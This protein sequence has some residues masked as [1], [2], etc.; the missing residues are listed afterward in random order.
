MPFQK[1]LLVLNLS[2][3][4]DKNL[5]KKIICFLNS[6][7][8]KFGLIFFSFFIKFLFIKKL[9]IFKK[10]CFKFRNSQNFFFNLGVF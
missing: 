1:Y 8:L 5:L 7:Y 2:L 10:K 4:I 3:K 9:R 6:L